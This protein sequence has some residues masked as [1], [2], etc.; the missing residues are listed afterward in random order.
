MPSTKRKSE[1]PE[2]ENN[3]KQK[4]NK[5]ENEG[6]AFVEDPKERKKRTPRKKKDQ[7]SEQTV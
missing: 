4:V 5:N 6:T 7:T 1:Q 3:K 2:N